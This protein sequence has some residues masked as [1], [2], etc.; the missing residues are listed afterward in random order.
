MMNQTIPYKTWF[1]RRPNDD[2]ICFLCGKG[3]NK[4]NF[5]KEH[6]FPK[7]L[8]TDFGLWDEKIILLNDTELSWQRA[9]LPCCKKC[10]NNHLSELEIIIKKGVI[11]GYE[12]FK[13]NVSPTHI[14]QWCQLIFYK[15]LHKGTFLRKD[16]KDPVFKPI[17]SKRIFKQLQMNHLLLRSIDKEILFDNFFP[18]S[19]FICHTKIP[20]DH[21]SNFYYFDRIS[22]QCFSIRMNDIGII[23][24]LADSGM[25]KN[26]FSS[27]YKDRMERQLSPAQFKNFFLE[28]VYRQQL[29]NYPFQFDIRDVT[30]ESLKLVL[31]GKRFSSIK[32]A[33][34][35]WN[36][37]DYRELLA[38]LFDVDSDSLISE[39]GK[40]KSLLYDSHGNWTDRDCDDEKFDR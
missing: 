37:K 30:E 24:V 38:K 17:I 39:N 15:L 22:E 34:K 16:Q 11:N 36:D 32:N 35:E 7:W 29:F 8:S 2:T 21:I 5:A 13:N 14:Y 12:Y 18:G 6:I 10:N 1:R 9:T 31:E 26:L 40:T 19:I 25:H 23:A 3:L 27:L 20:P 33:Y 4:D 28:V